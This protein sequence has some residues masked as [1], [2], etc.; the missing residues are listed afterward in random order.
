MKSDRVARRT[1]EPPSTFRVRVT[2][3]PGWDRVTLEG[4]L[5][6]ATA[7][8]LQVEL[9]RLERR[10]AALLVM[11]LR[12]LS[13]MD[14]TG[15]RVLLGVRDWARLGVRRLVFVRGPR[16]IHRLFEFV[17]V[18]RELDLIAD[19]TEAQLVAFESTGNA[20]HR[21]LRRATAGLSPAARDF[22]S[23]GHNPRPAPD[24]GHHRVRPRYRP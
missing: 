18:E 16:V 4:E 6:L 10:P 2:H 22:A 3:G 5:D 12:Q 13:F 21:A 11:D 9:D 14:L 23:R 19:L 1:S 15:M 8:L 20:P 17:G 24:D 7:P